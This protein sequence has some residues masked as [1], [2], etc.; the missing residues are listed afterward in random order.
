MYKMYNKDKYLTAY[1]VLRLLLGRCLKG[2][3][4]KLVTKIFYPLFHDF[5]WHQICNQNKST[6]VLHRI[7]HKMNK[8]TL[9]SKKIYAGILSKCIWLA[10]QFYWALKLSSCS[11][12]FEWLPAPP[13]DICSQEGHVHPKPPKSRLQPRLPMKT[14]FKNS[15]HVKKSTHLAQSR[16][17]R[18]ISKS[19]NV[20]V[21]MNV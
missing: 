9:L 8:T 19:Q 3:S 21:W 15:V 16:R 14:L 11:F 4:R 12:H 2:Y 13:E 17:N 7:F 5:L 1:Q 6:C 18:V 10:H 20:C